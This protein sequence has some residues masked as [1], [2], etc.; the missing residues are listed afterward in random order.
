LALHP[1][2][3]DWAFVAIDGSVVDSGTDTCSI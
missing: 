2:S 3:C 1:S